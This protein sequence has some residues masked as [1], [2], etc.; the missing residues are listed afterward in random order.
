MQI[1]CA[2]C[3][4]AIDG[5]FVHCPWCGTNRFGRPARAVGDSQSN[6]IT[7]MARTLDA[8]ERDL[9]ALALIGEMRK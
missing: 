6:R 3:G 7:R 1:V 8:L 5:D 9:T 4:R 2:G